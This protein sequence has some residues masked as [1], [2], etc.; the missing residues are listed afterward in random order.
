VFVLAILV[1]LFILFLWLHFIIAQDIEMIG[2]ELQVKTEELQR[3]ER[4]QQS[5]RKKIAT[6]S[7]QQ[8]MAERAEQLDYRTQDPVYILVDRPLPPA[9]LQFPPGGLLVDPGIEGELPAHTDSGPASGPVAN[10]P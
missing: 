2:R 3:V 6:L 4:E 10:T 5:L 1:V 9:S 7:T 8:R